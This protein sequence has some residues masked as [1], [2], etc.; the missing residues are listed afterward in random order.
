MKTGSVAHRLGIKSPK[1]VI[2]WTELFSEFFSQTAKGGNGLQRDYNH[3]D[4]AILNTIRIERQRDTDWED[5]RRALAEGYID[6][7]LPLEAAVIEGE[8]A[9]AIYGQI[10]NLESALATANS[11][12]ERVRTES[13]EEIERIRIESKTEIERLHNENEIIRR[14][15]KEHEEQILR[16][17]KDRE[18]QLLRD[19]KDKEA[20][21]AS[22]I[23]Q[24]NTEIKELFGEVG[25]WRARFE[26]L[27]ERLDENEKDK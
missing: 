8:N 10:K 13:R 7:N 4:V 15:S 20:Q 6:A 19:I 2:S 12:L 17:A 1:T 16:E 3:N 23:K 24:L 26:M 14:Q 21:L 25:A 9:L 11:E 22:D 27:K 18:L 5:I